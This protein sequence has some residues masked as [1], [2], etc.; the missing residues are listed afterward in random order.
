MEGFHQH[1]A[2]IWCQPYHKLLHIIHNQMDWLGNMF[3]LLRACFTRQKRKEKTCLKYLMIY[4][5]TP[6]SSNLQSPM[7]IFQSRS[8]RSDLPMSNMARHQLR[9][10]PELLRSKYKNEHL[11]L[12]D[13]H[14]GQHV[15]YQDLT[16]K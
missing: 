6:L 4:H 15:M 7:Q 8:V 11:L 12:Q 9:V 1:D 16:N 14:L 13:L 2:R 5:N 10:K 3:Q